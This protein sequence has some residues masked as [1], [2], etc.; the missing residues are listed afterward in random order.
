MKTKTKTTF[1]V[2]P[3]HE[4]P[5]GAIAPLG[6]AQPLIDFLASEVYDVHCKVGQGLLLL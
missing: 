4:A 2:F 3:F 6:G 1:Q 5:Q